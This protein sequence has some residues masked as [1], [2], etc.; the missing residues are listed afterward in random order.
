MEG[1]S[2]QR[3]VETGQPRILN[4]LEAYLT[5]HPGSASTALMIAEGIRS[6]LTC[7]LVGM[8]KPIGFLF[9][10]SMKT[11]TYQ[12]A[13]AEKFGQIALQISII[14]QKARLYQDLK[15]TILRLRAENLEH[16]KTLDKLQLARNELELANQKL[17]RSLSIEN[18]ETSP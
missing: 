9:F 5:V 2:L 18:G 16:K 12:N 17:V 10:S 11:G 6:S 3:I 14:V 15:R 1:S 8:G 13:H 4:D 7:P